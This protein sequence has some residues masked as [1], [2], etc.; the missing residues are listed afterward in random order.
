MEAVFLRNAG[1]HP[2]EISVLLTKKWQCK[3]YGYKWTLFIPMPFL[4]L[5]ALFANIFIIFT[6]PWRSE[7]MYSRQEGVIQHTL[8]EMEETKYGVGKKNEQ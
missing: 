5:I 4:F 8:E 1:N 7:I 2:P 6:E 3:S